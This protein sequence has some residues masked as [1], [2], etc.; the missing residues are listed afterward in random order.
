MDHHAPPPPPVRIGALAA[1]TGASVQALRYYERR[2]LIRPL[3]RQASG[4]REYTPETAHDVRFIRHAQQIGFTL[5]EIDELL[6]LRRRVARG[7][8]RGPDAVR[9]AVEA[10]RDDLTR[11]IG[12]L[13]AIRETL[14]GLLA[15]C[16]ELCR[17]ADRPAECP[18]F[19][20]ID[21]AEP[22]GS[23]AP[24]APVPRGGGRARPAALHPTPKGDP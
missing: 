19:E 4:Y 13:A 6:T 21:H 5:E 1:A 2:G 22:P 20:A 9:A 3:R 23:I 12:H 24:A 17:G 10:K 18:I 14:D 8:G 16:D 11:R 7:G 15:V